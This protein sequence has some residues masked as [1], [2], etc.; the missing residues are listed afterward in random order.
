[1]LSRRCYSADGE[2]GLVAATGG[3]L[4]RVASTGLLGRL[5]RGSLGR[6]AVTAK[7]SKTVI[8]HVILPLIVALVVVTI[9]RGTGLT[10]CKISHDMEIHTIALKMETPGMQ[11]NNV[12]NLC[13]TVNFLEDG[14]TDGER[15]RRL[16]RFKLKG[17]TPT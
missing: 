12:A 8:V 14:R 6:D 11:R 9:N 13:S 5:G 15:D 16:I 17:S 3:T 2:F 1:M 10:P 4:T 7:A